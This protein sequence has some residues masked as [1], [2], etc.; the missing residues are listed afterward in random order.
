MPIRRAY[1]IIEL[2]AVIVIISTI[3]SVVGSI[4][5]RASAMYADA[6]AQREAQERHSFALERLVR[7]L[8][9]AAPLVG[10]TGTPGLVTGESDRCVFEDGT[11][12]ELSG[13]DLLMTPAGGTSGVLARDISAFEL[14]YVGEDG[15]TALNFLG[16]DTLDM[17]RTIWIHLQSNDADTRTVVYLRASLGAP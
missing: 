12:F 8:R 14:T 13:T 3:S 1:T 17:T 11:T 16:G 9:E 2:I 4:V 15:N 5:S 6:S 7:A 10:S